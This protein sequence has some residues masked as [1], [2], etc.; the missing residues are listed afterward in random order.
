[1]SDTEQQ[2][3]RAELPV[4]IDSTMRSAFSSCPQKFFN[5]FILGLRP[6]GLS[7]D[8]HAGGVFS[9]SLE[10]FYQLF[11]LEQLDAKTALVRTL[12]TFLQLWGDYE[13]PA[14]KVTAKNKESIWA[15]IESYVATY[16]PRTDH[17]QPYILQGKPTFEFSF[18]IPLDFPGFPLHPNGSPFVYGGRADLLGRY[19]DRPCIRDEKTTGRLDSNWA[20][21]WDL[22]AQFL[23]YCWAAQMMGIDCTTV[24]VR[25]VVIHKRDIQHVEA[26]KLYA[27]W[28]ID[29]WFHQLKRD[30]NRIVQ[31]WN[32]GF[33]DYNL[34]E[35]CTQYGGCAFTRLCKSDKPER[36]YPDYRVE[37]WNP[38]HRNPIDPKQQELSN[39]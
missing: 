33:F 25:G 37:R 16:S 1:M 20:E 21:K 26:I 17:V 13:P 19:S 35:T 39:V 15:A 30:L 7:I 4:L 38:L 29:R 31:C 2:L 28:E 3:V 22:R 6:A 23:G 32:D 14:N 24:V 11:W 18:A 36:W 8:L 27:Q 10:R 34:G 9:G 5:E 12:P